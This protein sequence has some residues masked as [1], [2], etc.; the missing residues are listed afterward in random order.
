MSKKNLSPDMVQ[1]WLDSPVTAEFFSK[2]NETLLN[3]AVKPRYIPE[4]LKGNAIDAGTCAMYN[5]YVEGQIAGIKEFD[6]I[7]EEIR[8]ENSNAGENNE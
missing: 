2:V 4:D 6:V 1:E 8:E 3:V 5:A 7:K